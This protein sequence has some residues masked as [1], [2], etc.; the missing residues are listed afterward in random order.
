MFDEAI[1]KLNDLS[2]KLETYMNVDYFLH[3]TFVVAPSSF[4]A[5]HFY[6]CFTSF[7]KKEM[8]YFQR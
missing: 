5:L 4:S 7:Q 8:E 1:R 6:N 3:S 2:E